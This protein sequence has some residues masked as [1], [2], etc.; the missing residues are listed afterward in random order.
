M[1]RD[2][3][4]HFPSASTRFFRT[5]SLIKTTAR[6]SSQHSSPFRGW[7]LDSQNKFQSYKCSLET[8]VVLQLFFAVNQ[9]LKSETDR[10]KIRRDVPHFAIAV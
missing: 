4:K 1:H 9:K 3:N 5:N 2:N 10:L 6:L 7:E 8:C